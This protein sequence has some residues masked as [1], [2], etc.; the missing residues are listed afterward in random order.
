MQRRIS[1]ELR[2]RVAKRAANRCEYCGLPEFDSL[3]RFHIEHIIS[4]KHGGS[5][6][7][8]N[9]AYSCPDCNF[10]KGTNIGTYLTGGKHFT[11]FFDPRHDKW[12]DH[13]ELVEG[14]TNAKTE[15]EAVTIRILQMNKPD[16]IET[17]KMLW[18]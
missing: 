8:E 11:R 7:L 3:I 18:G 17:R 16:R 6:N 15:I 2:Q 14:V 9:L 5:N 4:I 1:N 12:S 13:F 10:Y